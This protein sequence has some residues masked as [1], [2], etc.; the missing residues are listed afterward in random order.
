MYI[1]Y[2]IIVVCLLY[3]LTPVETFSAQRQAEK[4]TT[5]FQNKRVPTYTAYK[6]DIT[7]SNVVEYERVLA[8]YQNDNEITVDDVKLAIMDL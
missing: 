6:E 2:I 1:V 7:N 3:Y 8:L 4:I 5:W